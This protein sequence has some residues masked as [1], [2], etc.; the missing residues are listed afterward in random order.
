MYYGGIW[1]VTYCWA[2]ECPQ[3][4]FPAKAKNLSAKDRSLLVLAM[5]QAIL[6]EHPRNS[7][8]ICWCHGSGFKEMQLPASPCGLAQLM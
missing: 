6:V 2:T 5:F 1:Q 3:S 7:W 4:K 8:I